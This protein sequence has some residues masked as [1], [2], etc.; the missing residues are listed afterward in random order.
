MYYMLDNILNILNVSKPY[1]TLEID[2]FVIL[3][4]N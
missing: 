3:T 1:D 2:I 4:L